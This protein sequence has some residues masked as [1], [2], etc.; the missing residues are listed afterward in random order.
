MKIKIC[1]FTLLFLMGIAFQLH[2]QLRSSLPKDGLSV[3]HLKIGYKAPYQDGKF[4]FI[5]YGNGYEIGYNYILS[6]NFELYIPLKFNVAQFIN[7][8]N[9]SRMIG[10]DALLRLYFKQNIERW[11]PYLI[12]GLGVMYEGDARVHG[13]IPLGA[14]IALNL[15]DYTAINLD[16]AYRLG[17]S[18]HRSSIQAG[19]GF[20]TFFGKVDKMPD[21]SKIVMVKEQKDSDGDGV[22][23]ELDL[24]PNEKG[25]KEFSGC[26]DKD[27]DGIPD[28]KDT[29]PELPGPEDYDGCPDSDEDG[30]PDNIDKCPNEPGTTSNNGCPSLDTDTGTDTD[31]DGV[32][33][34]NDSCPEEV[35]PAENN[36]CPIADS[37]NDG[38]SDD[39]DKCPEV[40]GIA[41]LGG[42]PDSDG[43]GIPDSDDL[44]PNSR[45]PRSNYGCPEIQ[46]EDKATLDVAMDAVQF[47]TASATLKPASFK[48]L[49]DI[50]RI[51][52]E[53]PDYDLRIGGHTDN[54]G[55]S[56]ANL[57]LSTQRA[58][59]CYEY[60]VSRGIPLSRLSYVGYGESKPRASNET[61][62]GR[63]KNRRVEFNLYIREK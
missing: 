58:R 63:A 18:E 55:S 14:G 42:C 16:L 37:D 49:D 22:V 27:G 8:E 50:V 34:V 59:A 43:D 9:Y 13:S 46:A 20:T 51:L 1:T 52:R 44:C 36:G 4:G 3:R 28:Y 54:V 6:D 24:C 47:E 61:A 2:A 19:I 38:V 31:G 15:N 39:M 10:L 53:Y 25:F 26:P 56:Q 33:D 32:I 11:N 23:D 62:L 60:I 45:G 40:Y 7:A 41:S 21:T 29:C 17:T 35:G 57:L 12:G 5:N 48:T 30:V